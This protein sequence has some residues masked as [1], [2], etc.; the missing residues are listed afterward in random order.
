MVLECRANLREAEA[1]A[2]LARKR[3]GDLD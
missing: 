2:D 1:Q 3:L